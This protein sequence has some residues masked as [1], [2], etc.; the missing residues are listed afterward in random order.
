MMTAEEKGWVVET[1]NWGKSQMVDKNLLQCDNKYQRDH[2]PAKA[3]MIAKLFDR[4]AFMRLLVSRRQDG[5]LWII[6][7]GNRHSAAMLR[8][9]IKSVPCEIQEGL[10]IKQ[11]A[12]IYKLV[13]RFRKP[14]GG[15]DLWKA[16]LAA[17]DEAA[18][19]AEKICRDYGF[20]IGRGSRKDSS[21]HI[22]CAQVVVAMQEAGTLDLVLSFIASC[23]RDGNARTLHAVL[24][25]VNRFAASL[26][27]I[28]KSLLD[29]DVVDRFSKFSLLTLVQDASAYSRMHN[30]CGAEGMR[31]AMIE[32]YNKGR[33]SGK[34]YRG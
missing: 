27:A 28:G 20:K 6:D 1:N 19:R 7:G 23:W 18:V 30:S 21:P 12:A 2:T 4:R 32:A 15:L 13:N 3:R 22:R 26:R 5:G 29:D 16:M 17:G 24:C 10:T 33:R 9:E 11:E 14:M 8:P 34:I 31:V 25:G